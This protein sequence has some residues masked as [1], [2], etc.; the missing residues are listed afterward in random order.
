M[1]QKGLF[2]LQNLKK[3][4]RKLN[5]VFTFCF[6]FLINSGFQSDVNTNVG[7]DYL[8]LSKYQRTFGN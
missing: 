6:I 1:E 8:L 2:L 7:H 5:L 3:W 4:N